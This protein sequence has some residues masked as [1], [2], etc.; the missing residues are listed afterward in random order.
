MRSRPK[1]LPGLVLATITACSD[2]PT[3][4]RT[5]PVESSIRDAPTSVTID[6][7]ALVLETFLWRNFMPSLSNDT[8]MIGVLR[9]RPGAADPV[10]DGL[11]VEEAW[12]ILGSR[13][14][15]AAP[16]LESSNPD[17]NYLEVVARGGPLWPVGSSLDVVVQVRGATGQAY[18]LAVRG[19]VLH[20][21]D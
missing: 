18:L 16:R 11:V 17:D 1:L 13:A 9:V 21:S 3:S 10:P 5:V 6:G 2:S 4:P 19:Q 14:W 7:V 20:R 8:R 12:V 15:Q